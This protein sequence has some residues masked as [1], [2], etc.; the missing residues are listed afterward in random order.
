MLF[1]SQVMTLAQ[2]QFEEQ[3][4]ELE[5]EKKKFEEEIRRREAAGR[6]TEDEN[7]ALREQIEKLTAELGEARDQGA[8]WNEEC[9]RLRAAVVRYLFLFFLFI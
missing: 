7:R 9:A 1:F 5:A 4:R 6:R 3:K 8:R 2:K